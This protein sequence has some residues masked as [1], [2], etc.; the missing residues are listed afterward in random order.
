MGD[1]DIENLPVEGRNEVN[2]TLHSDVA[3][4]IEMVH[5]AKMNFRKASFHQKDL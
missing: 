5:P 1:V 4:G 2:V 3:Q